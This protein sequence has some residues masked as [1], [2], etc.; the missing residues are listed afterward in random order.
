ML[1][2]SRLQY[3]EGELEDF[4]PYIGSRRG[5]MS[6][7]KGEEASFILFEGEFS[8]AFMR[9]KTMVECCTGQY[10]LVP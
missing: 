7:P 2:R 6:S 3:G 1:T 9:M 10:T 8:K 4:D 5:K